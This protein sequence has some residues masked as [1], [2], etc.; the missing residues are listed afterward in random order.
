MIDKGN[1]SAANVP[2]LQLAFD[3]GHSSIGWAVLQT[4]QPAPT[5]AAG[6]SINILGCG[7]VFA[8]H[9]NASPA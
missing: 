1:F 5:P 8:V 6:P 3:V 2:D 7:V 4:V 9:G